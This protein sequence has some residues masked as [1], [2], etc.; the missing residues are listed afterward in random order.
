MYMWAVSVHLAIQC[1][2][3]VVHT[4]GGFNSESTGG[5]SHC[6]KNVPK[7]ILE[8]QILFMA[9]ITC[10]FNFFAFTDL[11]NLLLFTDPKNRFQGGSLSIILYFCML[12]AF[13]TLQVSRIV[14][15]LCP[16][17]LIRKA[18]YIFGMCRIDEFSNIHKT[19]SY[20]FFKVQS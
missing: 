17:F 18:I 5:F 6:P 13:K 8:L 19:Y 4:K 11:H 1:T 7:T 14:F 12:K 20:F 9:L 3:Y 16:W 2:Q 10:Q 15:L